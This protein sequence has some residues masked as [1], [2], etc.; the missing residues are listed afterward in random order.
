MK[1][2]T[3][4]LIFNGNCKEALS[5]Y[6][7]CLDGKIVSMTTYKDSPVEFATENDHLIFDSHFQADDFILRASDSPNETSIGRNFA[8]FVSFSSSEELDKVFT[9][10][11]EGGS[12]TMPLAETSGVQFGM[13]VD[14]FGIQWMLNWHET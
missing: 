12:V 8:L 3:V 7:T 11:A 10:L 1:Q 13:L 9:K 6:E 2:L 4:Y 5:F 14:K